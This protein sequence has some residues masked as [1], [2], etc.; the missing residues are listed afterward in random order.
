VVT[1]NTCRKDV[2]R[3]RDHE[4]RSSQTLNVIDLSIASEQSRGKSLLL[5]DSLIPMA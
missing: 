5:I 2:K 4:D 3:Y 1:Q